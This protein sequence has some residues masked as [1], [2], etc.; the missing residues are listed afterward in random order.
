MGQG[1]TDTFAPSWG[2]LL[3]VSEENVWQLTNLNPF[4]DIRA[5]TIL[6]PSFMILFTVL[7]F[8]YIGDA[9]RDALDPHEHS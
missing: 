6:M 3:A 9:L 7:S 4:N 1:A 5:F 2:N 8:N